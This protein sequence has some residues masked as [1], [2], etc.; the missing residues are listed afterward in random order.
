[1]IG[2][3]SGEPVHIAHKGSD[4][5]AKHDH[6]HEEVNPGPIF[7]V[8]A[9]AGW[10][11]VGEPRRKKKQFEVLARRNEADWT[12]LHVEFDGRIRKE[13][14]ADLSKWKIDA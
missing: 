3:L 2:T 12:E 1:M 8:V 11:R 7:A 6:E 4:H 5:G 9:D 13:K 14:P 10:D